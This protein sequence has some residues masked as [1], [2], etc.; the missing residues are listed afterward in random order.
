MDSRE[1]TLLV[2]DH[3]VGDRIP[4]EF[5]GTPSIDDVRQEVKELADL[6]KSNG[7][8]IFCTSH[9]IQADTPTGNIVALMEAYLEFGRS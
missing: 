4:I 3:K 7:G 2:L 6:F 9:N 8:Y 1:R 5:W